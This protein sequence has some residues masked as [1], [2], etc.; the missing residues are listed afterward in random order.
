MDIPSEIENRHYVDLE[1]PKTHGKFRFQTPK[2]SKLW[3]LMTP[4][5]NKSCEFPSFSRKKRELK[6]TKFEKIPS[7]SPKTPGNGPRNTGSCDDLIAIRTKLHLTQEAAS[8]L[9]LNDDEFYF[10]DLNSPSKNGFKNGWPF[11]WL[12]LLLDVR[13]VRA[14]KHGFFNQIW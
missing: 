8:A 10:F 6:E 14:K 7:P 13:F 12:Q 4:Q 2:H 9:T 5:K 1:T 3:R 11:C